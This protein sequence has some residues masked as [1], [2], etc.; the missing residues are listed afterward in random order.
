ML[1]FR[2]IEFF[3]LK[4]WCF[5]CANSR[6]R[7]FQGRFSGGKRVESV[8]SLVKCVISVHVQLRSPTNV[9]L[10]KTQK[11]PVPPHSGIVVSRLENG[12]FFVIKSRNF[13]RRR[14]VKLLRFWTFLIFSIPKNYAPPSSQTFDTNFRRVPRGEKRN[15][16]NMPKRRL[17]EVGHESFFL[18][19]IRFSCPSGV[20]KAAIPRPGSLHLEGARGGL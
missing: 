16:E 4:S 2:K 6:K 12:L 17:S 8:V 7:R 20:K 1:K 19:K 15:E 5:G 3:W 10:E 13:A 14:G 18:Q 9:L 11:N